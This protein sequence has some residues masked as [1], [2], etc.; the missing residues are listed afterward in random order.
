MCVCVS[1]GGRGLEGPPGVEAARE[2]VWLVALPDQ[3]QLAGVL[4]LL[5]SHVL[6]VNLHGRDASG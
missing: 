1:L 5:G 4:R 2:A 3:A 6:D